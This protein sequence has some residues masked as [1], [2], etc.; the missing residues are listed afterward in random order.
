VIFC[1]ARHSLNEFSSA[2]A[3][4]KS[5]TEKSNSRVVCTRLAKRLCKPRG[6]RVENYCLP[7]ITL[8]SCL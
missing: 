1:N 7:V 8:R 3:Y 2:L 6:T 4:A 5:V